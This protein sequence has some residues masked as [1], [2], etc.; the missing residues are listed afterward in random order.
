MIN[1]SKVRYS[2]LALGLAIALASAPAF[3]QNTTANIGGRVTAADQAAIS[4]AT[5]SITHLPSGTTAQAVSD[6]NG[7]Y[8]ARGLRVGGPYRVT[9]TKDGKTE[10]IDNVFL[11]L[12]ETTQ[13]DASIGAPAAE[14]TLDAVEVTAA[15]VGYSPFSSTAVGAGTTVTRD[16]LD[17]FASIQRNLQDYARL[18]PRISQTDKE[19]GEISAGGQNTRFNSI[20]IDGVNT[21]DTFGLEGNN[22]PTAKQ[23]ISIDAI[24]E[25]QINISNYDVTQRGYTGANINAVTKSGTNDFRGSV[26]YVF[27]NDSMSGDRYIA[28]T[29]SYVA[30]PKSEDKTTGFTLGG[31]ILKDRLFFFASA[32]NYQSTRLGTEFSP[33]GGTG[34]QVFITQAEIDA[35]RNIMQTRYGVDIGGSTPPANTILDVKDRLLKLDWNIADNH[36][37]SLR[38]NK[39]DESTPIFPGFG[40][41]SLSLASHWYAQEKTFDGLVGQWFADWSDVFSTEFKA[42]RRNYDSVPLN[43]SNLPQ[44]TVQINGGTAPAGVLGGNRTLIFGTERSRH[45]NVLKTTT[46]NF[47]FGGNLFLGDHELKAGIDYETNEIYNAFLQDTRGTYNFGCISSTVAVGNSAAC[48][49]SLDSG[50]PFTY[51][52]QTGRPGQTLADGIAVWNLENLGFFLQDTWAVNYNLTIV[53]GL[54]ADVTGMP[55]TPLFNA[56]AA[57]PVAGTVITSGR[58]RATGGFG[59]NNSS[60][61]D[62]EILWQPRVGFNYTFDTDRQTQLR[63]G[64]GLFQG[65]AANVWLSNPYSNTGRATQVIGCGI[66]GFS[67]CATTGTGIFTPDTAAQPTTFA[68]TLPASNVDFLDENLD[69]PSVWKANLA[70]E[71]ELPWWGAVASAE[72]ILT[73]VEDGV[74]YQHL[75]LGA[76]TA[77]GTDGRALFWSPGGYNTACW[78]SGGGVITA[79]PCTGTNAVT[80]RWQNNAA[81]NNVLVAR[82]TSKGSGENL[83][84]QI[85]R[86]R[87]NDAWSWSLAYSYT[88]ATEVSPL[89]SSVSN[90]NWLNNN[91]F[92]PN[93]EVEARGNYVVR[94]RVLATLGFRHNFFGDYAT[95][96]GLVYEGRKGKPYSWTYIND[97]NG[98]GVGGNDLMYIPTAFGSG[99]VIFRGG[100]AEE[101]A[102]WNV[103]NQNGLARF[104]GGVVERNSNFAPW[105]NNVDV[106][107][108]QQLPGFMDGHKTELVLDILNVGNLINKDWGRI[109]EIGF[110]LNRSF[111]NYTGR[112]S[113]GRYVYSLGNTE[114]PFVRQARGESQWAAQLTL[115]YSF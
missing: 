78:G 71:H 46:D 85:S 68:G 54:R 30:P 99:E 62:G 77:T 33:L 103:V 102:F 12:A 86:G 56:A 76:P 94:D 82:P 5:V 7:R 6:A 97:L 9:I 65:S 11:Q 66:S 16:Q 35:V 3:A 55:D 40:T 23:P 47:Y 59:L 50:R 93:E 64:F 45:F 15:N 58:P 90:S 1:R 105:V 21:S 112:D 19:R 104:A 107:V 4:G 49:Q 38:Y 43:N 48:T 74:F 37:A 18:D 60:T 67:A 81:F 83:T 75:N 109:E 8:V 24:E 41:R 26:Y 73:Q 57:N 27:R 98:D 36:R 13:V 29:D 70:V 88:D 111:V 115:R 113:Q 39:T 96:F 79:A 42:S 108:S 106:R 20:T 31:P 44:V 91:T 17:S 63:G 52:V 34:T 95:D 100:V 22:L 101:Q 10:T 51:S 92:N 80:S 25:V 114:Q 87:Q 72:L 110:P 28:A 89:T 61:M 14:T 69:Q 53:A 2:K 32:E 84:F